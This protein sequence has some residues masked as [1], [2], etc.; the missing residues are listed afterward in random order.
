MLADAH[1]SSLGYLCFSKFSSEILSSTGTAISVRPACLPLHRQICLNL[2]NRDNQRQF[3]PK[4]TFWAIKSTFRSKGSLTWGTQT[5]KIKLKKIVGKLSGMLQKLYMKG[6]GHLKI[7]S[8]PE[9]IENCR[10]FLLLR[11]DILQK[12]VVWFHCLKS[13]KFLQPWKTIASRLR[14]LPCGD[15]A[16]LS[17]FI[18]SY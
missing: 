1:I 16:S 7:C 14:Q 5:R 2:I 6:N 13:H 4:C 10:Q 11:T 9:A 17:H 3:P 18:L 15:D 12:T 8:L